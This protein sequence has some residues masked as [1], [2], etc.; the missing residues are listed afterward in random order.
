[1]TLKEVKNYISETIYKRDKDYSN[2]VFYLIKNGFAGK[3]L[4][5]IEKE[6][7][8]MMYDNLYINC[9]IVNSENISDYDEE[10]L[11]KKIGK[12]RVD[13]IKRDAGLFLVL[14]YYDANAVMK[15]SA[16]VFTYGYDAI[17]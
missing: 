13:K 12:I 16:F 7:I 4:R 9:E 2:V 10:H 8:K 15:N 3:A 1:M 11:T 5:Q 17:N 6:D 14:N